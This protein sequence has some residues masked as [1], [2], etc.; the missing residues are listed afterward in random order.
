MHP[1]WV[2]LMALSENIFSEG[3]Y[4]IEI[5]LGTKIGIDSTKCFNF[6]IEQINTIQILNLIP[7][8]V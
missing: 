1:K 3:L 6:V 2:I 7:E 4:S 8:I 5:F